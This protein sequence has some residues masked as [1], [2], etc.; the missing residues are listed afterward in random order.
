MILKKQNNK[1]DNLVF[2]AAGLRND[3]AL[4]L[5]DISSLSRKASMKASLRQM[6]LTKHCL[7]TWVLP[8]IAEVK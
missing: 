7:K 2:V 6:A 8:D 3:H 5:G 1:P 4:I